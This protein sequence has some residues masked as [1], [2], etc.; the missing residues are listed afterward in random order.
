[1]GSRAVELVDSGSNS[2]AI[3]VRDNKIF[4]LKIEEA[5]TVPKRLDGEMYGLLQRLS[6]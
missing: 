5:L 4:D 1:M 2:R 6:I 3:G